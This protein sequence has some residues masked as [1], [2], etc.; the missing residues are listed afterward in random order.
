MEEPILHAGSAPVRAVLV[1]DDSLV[2]C[3]L[4]TAV[5][6]KLGCSVVCVAS[7]EQALMRMAGSRFDLAIC[8]ISLPDMDGLTLLATMQ[9]VAQAPPCIVLSAHDDGLHAEA[10][11]RA[12]ARAYMVK[13]LRLASMRTVL[14]ELFP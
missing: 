6:Q 1:V 11:L 13:P 8:D 14:D 3:M 2:E 10:A 5:L 12:G 9:V 7:A 4:A